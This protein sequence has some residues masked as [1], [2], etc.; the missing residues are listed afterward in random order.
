MIKIK[1]I[2]DWTLAKRHPCAVDFVNLV[3]VIDQLFTV[4]SVIDLLV[5]NSANNSNITLKNFAEEISKAN[6]KCKPGESFNY[7]NRFG[8][9]RSS[10]SSSSSSSSAFDI[11]DIC[12]QYVV[13]V[14]KQQAQIQST[15]PIHQQIP[16]PTEYISITNSKRLK[17]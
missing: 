17:L 12:E 15:A 11:E 13:Y 7:V 8:P 10:S 5:S 2:R 16:L 4:Q 1:I 14:A 3:W 9:G 6:S